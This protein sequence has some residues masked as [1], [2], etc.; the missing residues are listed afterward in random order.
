M[1]IEWS[2]YNLLF[3]SKRHGWLLYNSVC[4]C[5]MQL[6]EKTYDENAADNTVADKVEV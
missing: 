5:F 3:N 4:N 2:K 6:D 1:N